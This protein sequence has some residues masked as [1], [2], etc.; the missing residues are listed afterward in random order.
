VASYRRTLA[1]PLYRNWTLCE[2]VLQDVYIMF[3]LG[4][5]AILKALL[6]MKDIFDHHDIYYVYS[7]IWLDDY[8]VWIQ[9][10]R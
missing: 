8:C 1:Y 9:H 3:K 5:R 7:K 4:K 2:K 6:E 10:A